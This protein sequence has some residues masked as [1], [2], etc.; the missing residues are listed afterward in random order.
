MTY[1]NKLRRRCWTLRI[2]A[3]VV[4]LL[5]TLLLV[6]PAMVAGTAAFAQ[7]TPASAPATKV[8]PAAPAETAE[9][10]VVAPEVTVEGTAPA[11]APSQEKAQ[12]WWQALLMP[13]LSAL[14]LFIGAFLVAG[15]RKLV[16]LIEK[17]WNVDIPDSVEKLMYEKARWALGW[18]EEKAEKRLL[19]GDGKKTPGAE[20]L[21]EVVDMLEKFADS[22]GYSEEWQRDKI[23][24]LAE[25]VLHLERDK[26]STSNVKRSNALAEKK[27]NGDA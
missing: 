17:K 7:E 14:G 6:S 16:Q 4:G 8:A 24:A 5:A 23:E 9:P 20:K 22:L 12:K 19:Y 2:G 10:T 27:V 21:S 1:K 13:V 3:T 18:A 15:L 25:G 11:E 26:S